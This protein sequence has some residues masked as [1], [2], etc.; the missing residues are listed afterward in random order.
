M[1]EQLAQ[2]IKLRTITSDQHANLAALDYIE[3]FLRARGMLTERH[4]WDGYGSL[5]ATTRSMKHPAVLLNA[6]LDVT[7]GPAELFTLREAGDRLYGRGVFDMKFAIAAYLQLVDDL[8]DR[9]EEYDFGIMITTD[10]EVGG[11]KGVS[12][13]TAAGYLPTKVCITPDGGDDWAIETLAKGVWH[14]RITVPG[15]NAHSSRPWEGENAIDKLFTLLTQIKQQFAEARPDVLSSTLSVSTIQAGDAINQVPS[16]ASADI[17]MRTISLLEH[18]ALKETIQH[19]CAQYGARLTEV[20][21]GLPCINNL[22]NPHIAAFAKIIA[23]VTGEPT[24][25]TYSYAASDARYFNAHG[26][27]CVIV[28]PPGGNHH[29]PGEWIGKK[30]FEQLGPILATYIDSTA[31]IAV[32]KPAVAMSAGQMP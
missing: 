25:T 14:A 15:K 7:P 8:Q 26:V 31:R 9:L 3:R 22:T 32:Q 21:E 2:L 6:H 16:E 18:Q 20:A 23:T 19:V 10:E 27:P 24:R 5:V 30:G 1:Q 29:G 13:L 17:D 4:V 12:K 11:F 28:R